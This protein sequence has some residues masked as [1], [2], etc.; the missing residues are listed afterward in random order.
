MTDKV[1]VVSLRQFKY[2]FTTDVI[3][4]LGGE[5]GGGSIYDNFSISLIKVL[6]RS[7][8]IHLNY[9]TVETLL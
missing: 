7:M 6:T 1:K 9:L 3:I 4:L 8:L 2:V 5:D